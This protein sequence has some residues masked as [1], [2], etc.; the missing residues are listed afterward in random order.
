MRGSLMSFGPRF[1]FSRCAVDEKAEVV[2]GASLRVAAVI[3][4]VAEVSL[5]FGETMCLKAGLKAER[6]I[7]DDVGD[8]LVLAIDAWLF[9]YSVL[10]N[11][12]IEVISLR[13]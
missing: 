2:A 8:Q 7:V 11:A 10:A 13:S 12:K 4:G 1:L 5:Y 9:T 3:L 6:F